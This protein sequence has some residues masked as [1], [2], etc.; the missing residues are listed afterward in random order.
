MHLARQFI[1]RRALGPGASDSYTRSFKVPGTVPPGEYHLIAELD[2]TG[3][4]DEPSED[5]NASA[6]DTL[7]RINGA[8]TGA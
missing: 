2:A 3:A 8:D 5:N 7:L 4:I 1:A 6:S